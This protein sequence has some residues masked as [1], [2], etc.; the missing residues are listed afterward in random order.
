M[1]LGI[2]DSGLGGLLIAKS[3]RAHLPDIDILYF[4]DTLHLP[5]GNRSKETIYEYSKRGVEFL[6]SQDCNLIITACNTISASALRTLQQEYLP[7]SQYADRRILGVVVPTLECARDDGYKRL[8]LI[9]TNYTV[10]SNVFEDELQKLEPDI[11]IFQVQTP[12]LVPLIENDG[13][14]WIPS[15]LEH[16]LTPLIKRNIE[17]LILGCTHYPFLKDEIR[18]IIGK[19]IA[20]ITQDEIVPNKLKSYLDRHPEISEKISH[21]GHIE[22]L[23]SDI[24]QS[25]R[26]A[27][28]KIYGEPIDIEHVE[29]SVQKNNYMRGDLV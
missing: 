20:L 8:G 12:L 21:N 19:D 23:V 4:G 11:Q 9:A 1:K 16:Y 6:F 26:N 29:F 27:A 13:M 17:C 5:Y 24:T 22:F 14:Q 10:H 25:Y 2:F 3:I 28:F 18:R 15:V 7:T